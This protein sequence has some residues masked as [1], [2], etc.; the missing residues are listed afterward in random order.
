MNLVAE[1][2]KVTV[3]E[4]NKVDV[5]VRL[6]KFECKEVHLLMKDHK[7]TFHVKHDSRL[8]NPS[9]SQLGKVAKHILD[10]TIQ[11][12]LEKTKLNSWNNTPE[13]IEWF[14]KIENKKKANFLICDVKAMYASISEDLVVKAL[15]WAQ[16]L[17]G[18]CGN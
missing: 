7:S 12:V 17:Q 10:T 13:V 1:I 4:A 5:A 18:S 3:E 8:I 2:I 15:K 11:V 14:N 6:E 16:L 9:K